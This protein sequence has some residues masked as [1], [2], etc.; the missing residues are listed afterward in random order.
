MFFRHADDYLY[1]FFL[2]CRWCSVW[3]FRH[4]S[5]IILESCRG[6]SSE[7]K[8]KTIDDAGIGEALTKRSFVDTV[9]GRKYLQIFGSK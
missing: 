4:C 9:F 6:F 1:S 7:Y 8:E 5:Q 2:S 3:R